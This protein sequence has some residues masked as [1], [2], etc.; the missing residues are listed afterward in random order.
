MSELYSDKYLVERCVEDDRKYQEIFYRKFAPTM[1]GICKNYASDRDEAMD[2]LQNGFISVFKNI[3]NYRF[4][5]SLEGWVKRIII[6]RA[7]EELRSKKRYAEVLE[8]YKY[9]L[10]DEAIE[11]TSS[12]SKEALAN[13]KSLVNDLPGKAGLVLKLYVLEGYTHKEIAEILNVSVGT[14]KSQLNRARKLIK[15]GLINR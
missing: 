14:S 4:E 15:E 6:R 13:V 9:E 11:E 7:I 2:F 5:G 12:Y 10:E 3:H 8:D 1:Y